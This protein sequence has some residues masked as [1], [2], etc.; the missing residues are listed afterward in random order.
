MLP[1]R[2][3]NATLRATSPVRAGAGDGFGGFA[4]L[5]AQERYK[6][7]YSLFRG[8]IYGA[9]NAIAMEAAG[10]PVCIGKIL[11]EGMEDD[12]S[13]PGSKKNHLVQSKM[14]SKWKSKWQSVCHR[15]RKIH[16]RTYE[17]GRWLSRNYQGNAISLSQNVASDTES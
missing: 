3:A 10:Q 5:Q 12:K 8:T 17:S 2:R 11:R 6:E 15:F 1:S 14:Q 13:K 4:A 16:D 9:I 7:R